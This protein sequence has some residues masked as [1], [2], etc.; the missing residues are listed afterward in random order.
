[1]RQ[2][3]RSPKASVVYETARLGQAG[4]SQVRQTC[5]AELAGLVVN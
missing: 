2:V 1:M 3:Y 5:S 4:C